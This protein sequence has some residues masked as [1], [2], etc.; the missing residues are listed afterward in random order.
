MAELPSQIFPETRKIWTHTRHI[1][2]FRIHNNR[3]K[4]KEEQIKKLAH[5]LTADSELKNLQEK[6][7]SK[8][9]KG[10]GAYYLS[11]GGMIPKSSE[12]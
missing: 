10:M 4:F 12:L 6:K 8:N 7:G 1:S 2:R 5:S 11:S 3:V 9:Q